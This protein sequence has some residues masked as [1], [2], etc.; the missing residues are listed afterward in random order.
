MGTRNIIHSDNGS[1]EMEFVRDLPHIQTSY[2]K[3]VYL[4]G[5]RNPDTGRYEYFGLQQIKHQAI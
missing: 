5:L 2:G 1:V 3:L 4:A